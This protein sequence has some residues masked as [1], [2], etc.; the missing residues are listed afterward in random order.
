MLD[1]NPFYRSPF[2]KVW[3]EAVRDYTKKLEDDARKRGR[4]SKVDISFEKWKDVKTVSAR[5]TTVVVLLTD[6]DCL[7]ARP[8]TS[9]V[10]CKPNMTH[11][12]TRRSQARSLTLF[13]ALLAPSIC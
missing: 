3:Q 4:P 12:T 6:P 1:E 13:K 8:L 5:V 10:T 2:A 7:P 11:L 9:S